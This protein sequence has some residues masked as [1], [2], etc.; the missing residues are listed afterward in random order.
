MLKTNYSKFRL[1]SVLMAGMWVSALGLAGCGG[2]AVPEAPGRVSVAAPD[3]LLVATIP[4][5]PQFHMEPAVLAEPQDSDREGTG[6]T[7]MTAPVSVVISPELA[8]LETARLTVETLAVEKRKRFGRIN[9]MAT[10]APVVVYTPAQIRA[11]YLMPGLPTVAAISKGLT[12]TVAASLGAGQTIYII[13]AYDNPN[14]L[15]DL[16]TFSQKFGLP[17]CS[18]MPLAVS[19]ALPLAKANPANGCTF[20]VA[21]STATGGKLATMAPA[22]NAGWAGEIALDVQW[23]HATAPLARIV[24]VEATGAQVGSLGSAIQ[25]ANS[26][27][28]GTVSMS[29]GALEGPWTAG[30]ESLFQAAGMTYLAATGDSGS[31]V[32]WPAVSSKVLAVGGTT[33]TYSGSGARSEVAWANTGGGV[34]AYTPIPSY[35]SVLSMAS[36]LKT[37]FISK[38][39]GVADVAFNADPRTGQYVVITAPGAKVANW[40]SYGGTSVSAPQW[41]GLVAVIQASRAVLNKAALPSLHTALYLNTASVPGSYA[42]AFADVQSGTNGTCSTCKAVVGY[43]LLTGLG[44]PKVSTLQKVLTGI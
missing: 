1:Q 10:T 5:N 25:L 2:T 21:Y 26:M 22:Y 37:P 43:D 41:A 13:N 40:F 17:G 42:G 35:Q 11:A 15:T 8:D 12:P 33:L 44:T 7:A 36:V 14:A 27:G 6:A 32:N 31:Q 18:F 16:N 23:A 9:P 3:P 20:S 30:V 38:M 39:R 29:F 24:L 4:I 28:S 19:T 34:S